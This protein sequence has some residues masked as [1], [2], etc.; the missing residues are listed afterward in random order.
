MADLFLTGAS[1]FVGQ[2]VLA[3]L[4]PARFGRIVCLARSTVR[5]G[6]LALPDA[7]QRAG[8]VQVLTGD[9]SD[10]A[11][12]AKGMGAETTVL[13]LAALTGKAAP[14]AYRLV[15]T[16]GTR[17]LLE[18][19]RTAG[20]ARFVYVSTIAVAFED[21]RG[22]HYA[23]SKQAAEALVRDSGLPFTIVRPTIVLGSGSPV[24]EKLM[25]L[26]KA[27]TLLVPGPGRARIQPIDVDDLA[28]L[29]LELVQSGRCD[30]DTI[31][32]GGPES[33]SIEAFLR[34]AHE[35]SVGKPVRRAIHLPVQLALPILRWLEGLI[36][37]LLPVS[38]GQ[39][40]SFFNDG[41]ARDNPLLSEHAGSM[42]R[43]DAM[44]SDLTPGEESGRG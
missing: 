21:T 44:L 4:E 19:A 36:G 17:V 33:L 11:P 22:Y 38:A 1:G 12:L 39:F 16:E 27:A 8:N 9:L 25:G 6:A 24:G 31:D 34:R 28:R 30:G 2:R 32:L 29:L 13:H 35:R 26:A 5:T 42:K 41:L 10:P 40:A 14:D 43:I 23:H 18:A 20:A 3:A 15:N 7:L 37:G